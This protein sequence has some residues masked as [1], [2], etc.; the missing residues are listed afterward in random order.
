M[1]DKVVVAFI[2]L[3][4]GTVYPVYELPNSKRPAPKPLKKGEGMTDEEIRDAHEAYLRHL[5]HDE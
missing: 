4:S 3:D 5:A 1:E 2:Q